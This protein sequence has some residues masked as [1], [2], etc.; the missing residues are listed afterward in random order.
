MLLK[1][2]QRN[3]VQKFKTNLPPKHFKKCSGF[4]ARNLK[5]IPAKYTNCE[6]Y[7]QVQLM[8]ASHLYSRDHGLIFFYPIAQ[9]T[10][11][12]QNHE[13]VSQS[14]IVQEWNFLMSSFFRWC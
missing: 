6:I 9:P 3:F 4:L 14:F 7:N 5:K 13:V 10:H 12:Y 2:F 8:T 11:A 1:R